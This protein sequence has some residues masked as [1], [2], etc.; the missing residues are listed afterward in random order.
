MVMNVIA[1]DGKRKRVIDLNREELIKE[2][3]PGE[4][5]GEAADGRGHN[6]VQQAAFASQGLDNG[7]QGQ[8]AHR[9]DVQDESTA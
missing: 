3:Q 8:G 1:K 4:H 7:P 2:L 9:K 6:A 5:N